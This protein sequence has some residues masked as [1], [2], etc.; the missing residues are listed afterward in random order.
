MKQIRGKPDR[1]RDEDEGRPRGRVP[2]RVLR[3]VEEH[4]RARA[5]TEGEGC[6]ELGVRASHTPSVA[7]PRA[8]RLSGGR[9]DLDAPDSRRRLA[10]LEHEDALPGLTPIA[11]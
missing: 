6:E 8:R 2:D 1:E 9:R 7:R 10:R 11:L 5:R 3:G 4:Q